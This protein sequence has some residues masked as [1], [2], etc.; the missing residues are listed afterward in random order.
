MSDDALN[1]RRQVEAALSPLVGLPLSGS[2]RAA[3]LSVFKFGA[4]RPV[5]GGEVGD[6][7]L[8]VACPW[9]VDG[10]YGIITGRAELFEAIDPERTYADDFDCYSEPN[11]QDMRMEAWLAAGPDGR[12]T[13]SGVEADDFGG[14]TLN[15]EGGFALRLFPMTTRRECWRVFVPGDD[16]P[17][18]VVTGG[19][20]EGDDD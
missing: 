20:V 10:P 14:V 8:H 13:V 16:T 5:P 18:F 2:H 1:T 3:D 17:H 12:R 15:F 11:L 7:A 6:F 4:L 9:R 19:R